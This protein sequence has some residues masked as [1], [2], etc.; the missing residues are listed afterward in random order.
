MVEQER[1]DEA[2]ALAV[3]LDLGYVSVLEV[4]RWADDVIES[5]PA[6]HHSVCEVSLMLGRHPLDVAAAL[7]TIPGSPDAR[8]VERLITGHLAALLDKDLSR[9]HKVAAALFGLSLDGRIADPD[10]QAMGGWMDAVLHDAEDGIVGAEP[11]ELVVVMLAALEHAAGKGGRFSL[12]WIN[13]PR[14]AARRSAMSQRRVRGPSPGHRRESDGLAPH[15]R[16]KIVR[17]NPDG[18]RDAKAPQAAGVDQAVDGEGRDG[19]Q[20]GDLADREE[21]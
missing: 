19:Q 8:A 21:R 5:G 18:V 2:E 17:P 15:V 9:A 20:A 7:R 13:G 3:G 12:S 4:I 11:D 16:L 6:A 10:L 14:G 1:R